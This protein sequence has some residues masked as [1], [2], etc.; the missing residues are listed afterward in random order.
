MRSIFAA[1]I[2]MA[3]AGAVS[4]STVTLELPGSAPVERNAVSYICGG[5]TVKVEY[6]NA[7]DNSLAVLTLGGR[8]IVT[9]TVLSGSGAR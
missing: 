6:I 7:G 3:A 2:L 4:A 8:T 5:Q 1:I 9:V